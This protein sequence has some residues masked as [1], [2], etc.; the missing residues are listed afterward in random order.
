MNASVKDWVSK[1]E[2]DFE[3]AQLVLGAGHRRNHDAVCFHSQQCIEKLLKAVLIHHSIKPPRIHDLVVLSEQVR[4]AVPDWKAEEKD[5][6]FLTQGAALFRYPA[7]SAT[8][9]QAE[10]AVAVCARLRDAL[11]KLLEP[12]A[13]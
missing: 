2:G 13:K 11:L 8:D 7:E 1:A 10:M 6:R 12:P 3:V 4:S 5:L 9:R